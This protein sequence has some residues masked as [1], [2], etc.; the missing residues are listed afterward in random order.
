MLEKAKQKALNPHE[1]SFTNEDIV[2]LF[3]NI[4]QILEFHRQL[5]S[6][7]DSYMEPKGPTYETPISRCYL[8]HVS[9][10]DIK[11]KG[12]DDDAYI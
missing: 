6:D 4:E 8:K 2:T 10:Q 12:F 11:V 7:L 1:N 3:C 9:F 5:L